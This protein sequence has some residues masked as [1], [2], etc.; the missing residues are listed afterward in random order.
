MTS[1]STL[2]LRSFDTRNNPHKIAPNVPEI[3]GD[4]VCV[5]YIGGNAVKTDAASSGEHKANGL[6]KIVEQQ[7]TN[8]FTD[9]IP[10]YAVKYDFDEKDD[11][12]RNDR[13]R[14]V[15][16][17]NNPRFD[18]TKYIILNDKN[19]NYKI[20]NEILPIF[21]KDKKLLSPDMVKT[22]FLKIYLDSNNPDNTKQLFLNKLSAR[23]QDLGYNKKEVKKFCTE[24]STQISK[25][26]T[27]STEYIDDIFNKAILPRITNNGKRLPLNIAM[28]RIRK[29]NIIAHCHGAYVT[30]ELESRAE[31][32]MRNLGYSGDEIKQILSQLLVVAHAPSQKPRKTKM[33]FLGFI[34]A[35]D[36]TVATTDNYVTQYVQANKNI[37]TSNMIKQNIPDMKHKWLPAPAFLGGTGGNMFI[38]ARGFTIGEHDDGGFGVSPDEHNNTQYARKPYQTDDGFILNLMARNVVRNG[39]KNSL[40]QKF[41]PLPD[42]AELI[43]WDDPESKQIPSFHAMEKNG[44]EFIGRVLTFAK[45]YINLLPHKNK[46]PILQSKE[47]Y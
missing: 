10:V 37:D 13:S 34:S 24:I 44:Q 26:N 5:L 16:R 25:D 45:N 30:H 42:N 39:I 43:K 11:T 38:I 35:Y 31:N 46:K 2:V 22:F 6:A 12:A 29:L 47:N 1:A 14:F 4:Q 28:Q 20:D 32:T 41:T 15:F 9:D 3:P 40:S 8:V 19:I 21:I 17:G 36:N 27:Y 33:H 18:K 23:L 7:I